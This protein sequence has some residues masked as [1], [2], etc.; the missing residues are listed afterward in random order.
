MKKRFLR[1]I[2]A[3]LAVSVLGFAG[4]AHADPADDA[5]II[6]ENL[7][8]AVDLLVAGVQ[9]AADTYTETSS[10]VEAADALGD[11]LVAAGS[12]L[13]A[14]TEQFG[15]LGLGFSLLNGAI[16]GALEPY[17]SALDDPSTA[18][19]LF[20]PDDLTTILNNLSPALDNL[21]PTVVAIVIEGLGGNLMNLV[22]EVINLV[23]YIVTVLVGTNYEPFVQLVGIPLL[24]GLFAGA[25]YIQQLE[26]GLAPLFDA[27]DP[28]TAPILEALEGV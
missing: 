1:T 5:A 19:D 4:T 27:L 21:Q 28:V 6:L 17:L 20:N 26:E 2:A 7:P 16:Q 24:V 25:E 22:L 14:G 18:A 8:A 11:A 3:G 9:D 23:G 10:A 13:V 12:A 15:A